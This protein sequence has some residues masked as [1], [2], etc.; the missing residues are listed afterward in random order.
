MTDQRQIVQSLWSRALFVALGLFGRPVRLLT[1]WR[2]E[3]Q[4]LDWRMR[5]PPSRT[6][7]GISRIDLA[8][9]AER[10]HGK[11]DAKM[12]CDL[13]GTFALGIEIAHA[14]QPI[15]KSPLQFFGAKIGEDGLV[16]GG[17]R[18]S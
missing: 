18:L 15:V 8:H 16:H 13:G 12:R 5:L 11:V 6:T 4:F 14:R 2:G 10:L 17:T 1:E 7:I 9:R 3:P